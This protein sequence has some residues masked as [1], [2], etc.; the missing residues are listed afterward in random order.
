LKFGAVLV[1]SVLIHTAGVLGRF[2]VVYV[3]G[4]ARLFAYLF[5]ARVFRYSYSYCRLGLRDK[6][7]GSASPRN[8]GVEKVIS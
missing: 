8:G 3:T 2:F 6:R 4:G 5:A 7:N 1:F